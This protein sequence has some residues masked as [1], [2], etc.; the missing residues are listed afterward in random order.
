MPDDPSFHVY[1]LYR[2]SLEDN[3]NADYLNWP[4]AQGA[5]VGDGGK[6]L[7]YGDQM[8]WMVYNDADSSAHTIDLGRTLPLG[9]EIQQTVWASRE[10]GTDTIPLPMKLQADHIGE[11]T[12]YVKVYIEDTS[13]LTGHDYIVVFESDSALGSTWNLIDRTLGVPV[14]SDQTGQSG[15]S[16]SAPLVDGMRV[17]VYGGRFGVKAGDASSYPTDSSKWGWMVPSGE[18]RFTWED[19][20]YGWEGFHGALG[21]GG[22]GDKHGYGS[23]TPISGIDLP[24]VLLKLA[25]VDGSGNFNPGDEN[26]SYACR[27]IRNKAY[28]PVQP[29]FAAYYTQSGGSYDYQDF[30]KSCPLSAWNIDVDPPQRLAVGYLENN[31]EYAV[32]DGKYYPRVY[33]DF[34]LGGPA[35][36]S[37]NTSTD[38]PREWLWIYLAPYGETP[39]PAYQQNAIDDSMPVVYWATWNRLDDSGWQSGDEFEIVPQAVYDNTPADTFSFRAAPITTTTTG[40]DGVSIYMSYKILNKGVN[41]IDS[42]YF[43]LWADPDIGDPGNDLVGCDTLTNTFFCYNSLYWDRVYDF[44]PPAL[45]FKYLYGPLVPSPGNTAVFEG[46]EVADHRNLGLTAFWGWVNVDP[47]NYGQTF[48]ALEG[49]NL[50]GE[51]YVYN[52]DTTTFVHSGDPVTGTGDL[53]QNP[54][55]RSMLGASGPFTLAPGDSQ[56]V[57]IKMAIGQGGN[58]YDAITKMREIINQPFEFPT[59]VGDGSSMPELPRSFSLGQNYPNPFNPTT[60]INYWLPQRAHVEIDVY[61]ILGQ[62]VTTL[63]NGDRAAGAHTAEWNGMDGSGNQVSTGIYFYRIKAGDFVE[64]KKML[65]L[66]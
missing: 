33:T 58:Q 4:V 26:V 31:A 13:L 6:P 16:A 38:G 34:E 9:I 54:A 65:L 29:E 10:D 41:D 32:L 53:D 2:D 36:G 1:K 45:G 15:D 55:D 47:D 18:L 17:A 30:A 49:L 40:P 57:L 7:M 60:R 61:N 44:D 24:R 51:P 11:S 43:G 3:P 48:R 62:K 52:G 8:L 14:L 64:S 20:S 19:A 28:S 22:P 63:V 39:D 66:K 42:C 37:S 25:D 35:V 23:Y 56:Y 27:Y 5:P 46:N 50:A 12:G 21:W 59:A